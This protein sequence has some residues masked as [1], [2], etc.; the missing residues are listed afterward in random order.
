MSKSIQF[1][2]VAGYKIITPAGKHIVIDP[3]LPE[4]SDYFPVKTKDLGKVDLLLITHNAFDHFGNAADVV[5]QYG[6]HVI[7]AVDVL[8]NL[9]KYH[10]IKRELVI[11][12]IWG[13]DMEWEGILVN[14]IESHHWS[15]AIKDDGTFLSGPAMG[16]IIHVDDDTRIYHPA[17]TGLFEDMKSIGE[18]YKP[19]LGLMHV[20][21]PKIGPTRMPYQESYKCGELSPETALIASKRLGLEEL[22]VSHY[23]D[24]ENDDVKKFVELVKENRKKGKYAPKTTVLKPGEVFEL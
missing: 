24:P 12:T 5:K 3:Y 15:F 2:G 10:N 23:V 16:F 6:C 19:T 14:P 11:P 18:I 4:D 17:D 21:L 22:I 9:V 7:C 1:L 8:H 20:T 13:M